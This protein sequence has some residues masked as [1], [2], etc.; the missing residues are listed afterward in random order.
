MCVVVKLFILQHWIKFFL[1]YY[2]YALLFGVLEDCIITANRECEGVFKPSFDHYELVDFFLI[3]FIVEDYFV[4]RES[5]VVS[6]YSD[7]RVRGRVD[8]SVLAVCWG[9]S[10]GDLD[11]NGLRWSVWLGVRRLNTY[12]FGNA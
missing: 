3:K 8:Y 5:C 2:G 1:Y 9:G 11:C 7:G 6:K 4:V 10:G 12:C